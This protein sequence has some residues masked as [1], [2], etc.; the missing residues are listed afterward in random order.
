MRPLRSPTREFR[1]RGAVELLVGLAV[2]IIAA[3]EH[4]PLRVLFSFLVGALM[5]GGL[6]YVLT[7][8][9][10]LREAVRDPSEAPSDAAFEVAASTWRRVGASEL[11]LVPLL[12][13][14]LVLSNPGIFGGIAAGNG[15]ALITLSHWVERWQDTHGVELLR[16]PRYRW[17]RGD[18]HRGRG[19]LDSRD[20]YV[21]ARTEDA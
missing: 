21:R 3:T 7:Y 10:Y 20:F 15:A 17:R 14:A 16:E 9:R 4:R 2:G 19:I 8:R 12:A 18:K 11:G 1:I 13:F 5:F 6:M